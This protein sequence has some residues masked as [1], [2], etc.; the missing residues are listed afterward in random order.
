VG[1]RRLF[2]EDTTTWEEGRAWWEG[3]AR[4]RSA[5][6]ATAFFIWGEVGNRKI[7]RKR[8][9]GRVGGNGGKEKK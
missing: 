4:L 8:E 9:T 5:G 3:L 1:V 7:D 2:K 6:A